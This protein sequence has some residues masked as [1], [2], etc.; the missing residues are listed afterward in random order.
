MPQITQLFVM[1]TDLGLPR[2]VIDVYEAKR[3]INDFVEG[4]VKR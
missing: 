3:L 2:D 4:R 1:L